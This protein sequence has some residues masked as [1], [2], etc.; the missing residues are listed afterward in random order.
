[1]MFDARVRKERRRRLGA[2]T[3]V[4]V[5]LAG[6][7]LGAEARK[8]EGHSD[9]V[10]G[11]AFF[12][13]GR[14]AA[15]CG[16]R[17]D[18]TVRVW[19][20]ETGR[21]LRRFSAEG[22]GLSALAVSPDGKAVLA[23]GRDHV[24]RLWMV[25]GPP[26]A[27]P[28]R[29][30]GHGDVVNHVAF[31]PDGKLAASTSWDGTAR[32]WDV[33][34]GK[35]LRKL[36]GH[37]GSVNG[38]SFSPDGR[39]LATGGADHA[40]RIWDASTG[41]ETRK[42]EG[43]AGWVGDVAFAP[44]GRRIASAGGKDE[45][46]VILWDAS[47]GAVARRIDAPPDAG[48]GVAFAGGGRLLAI[49][50][51]AVAVFDVATG[52]ETNRLAGHGGQ[53]YAFSASPDGRRALT[54][55]ADK[56]VRLWDLDAASASPAAPFDPLARAASLRRE[57][58]GIDD[59]NRARPLE[60]AFRH[61]VREAAAGFAEVRPSIDSRPRE[62]TRVVLNAHKKGFDAIKFRTPAGEGAWDLR[63]R[64]VVPN[65]P[66]GA[67]VRRF[68]IVAESG[69]VRGP[70]EFSQT[71]DEPVEG[72]DMPK[73]L[74]VVQVL[75]N[76]RLRPGATYYLWFLFNEG[77][78]EVPTSLKIELDQTF[79]DVA[80]AAHR[81]AEVAVLEMSE[82]V[83]GLG[84]AARGEKGAVHLLAAS[85]AEVMTI[86]PQ[87]G[88]QVGR[89][90]LG[91]DPLGP[92]PKRVTFS[93]DGRVALITGDE[94]MPHLA[95]LATGK[96]R[97]VLKGAG[98]ASR[99]AAL[100]PDGRSAAVG[101][102]DGVI[103]LWDVATGAERRTFEGHTDQ[104]FALA[105]APDGRRIASGASVTDPVA[106]IWDTATGQVRAR[107]EG[108]ARA[109]YAVTFSRDGRSVLTGGEDGSVRLFDAA[110]GRQVRAFETESDAHVRAV[111]FLPD[112]RRALSAG[113]GLDLRLWDVV[114]GEPLARFSGHGQ[115]V[116]LLAVSPDGRFAASADAHGFLRVWR[117]PSRTA[118][119]KPGPGASPA[120]ARLQGDGL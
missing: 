104:V 94:P 120:R 103:R 75:L 78:T 43:H 82:R 117:L 89:S 58:E 25:S 67:P 66:D 38:V 53:I 97:H 19:D 91:P 14:R 10:T 71:F 73:N 18:S 74:Q 30:E 95:D 13:D 11:V 84:F 55:G 109:V 50:S 57:L 42:L 86:D 20:V 114:T 27:R 9:S 113:D 68:Y 88:R 80:A 6:S 112:R 47:T 32:L 111:A 26:D 54:G 24:I 85:G 72:L 101:F 17:A 3:A 81:E 46:V 69:D 106:R 64:F 118:D 87:T 98:S 56:T 83:V 65:G 110:T 51:D 116:G 35:E 79:P 15:S 60:Y 99:S 93:Q 16:D 2:W 61:A 4:G 21:E 39:R 41:R 62:F 29:F 44:D 77:A 40:V 119:A 96:E 12:A 33:A 108:N 105:F 8:F 102:E 7:A 52:R 70:T 92:D 37:Q 31:S 100:S 49:E 36:E 107:L 76:G 5:M 48:W 115:S 1:M 22:V 34:S 59:V 23:A 28:R 45:P 90:P 63:W